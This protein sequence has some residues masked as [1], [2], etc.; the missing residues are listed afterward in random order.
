VFGVEGVFQIAKDNHCIPMDDLTGFQRFRPEVGLY[1]M[2]GSLGAY[3]AEAVLALLM[4]DDRM[5]QDPHI[6][7]KALK[8]EIAHVMNLN[9]Y[10]YNVLAR[11]CGDHVT[12]AALRD[13]VVNMVLSSSAF[14]KT[15]L[16]DQLSEHPLSLAVGDIKENLRWLAM[17]PQAEDLTTSDIQAVVREGV[18]FWNWQQ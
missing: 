3:P 14:I 17:G 9:D 13:H 4:H 8:D 12:G 1:V 10:T 16:L 7:K 2:V 6:Y 18:I 5:L 15:N 11:H